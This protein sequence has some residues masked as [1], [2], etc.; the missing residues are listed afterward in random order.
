MMIHSHTSHYEYTNKQTNKI[1]ELSMF[2]FIIIDLLIGFN[3]NYH[4]YLPK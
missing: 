4:I 1:R 3:V 2:F